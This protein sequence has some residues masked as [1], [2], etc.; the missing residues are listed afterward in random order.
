MSAPEKTVRDFVIED[1]RTAAVFERHGLDFCCGG[2]LPLSE[3]CRKSAADETTVRAEL[4]AAVATPSP[5]PNPADWE[6]D[7]LADHIVT[8]HH[9]FVRQAMPA[10]MQH[11]AKVA[12][13]HGGNHPEMV[14]VATLVE[15]VVNEM[16]LHMRK[17]EQILFP[18]ITDMARA[19]RDGAP[20]PPTPF[21]S[22]SGPIHVMEAEHEAAGAAMAAIRRLTADYTPPSD[23]CTTYRVLFQELE[24]FERDLHRHVHL[25]NN[26]LFPG[27]GALEAAFA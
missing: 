23:A 19:H 1:F 12:A 11:A 20:L 27:A 14:D 21:G 9:G 7:L 16:T 2:G 8:T 13:V 15:V 18:R 25:E 26:I 17:E 4:A 22:V 6:L 24:A 10:L 3:A 5:D